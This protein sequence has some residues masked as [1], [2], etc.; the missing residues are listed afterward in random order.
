M[1]Q[2]PVAAQ[3]KF[4][5]AGMCMV[6]MA[7]GRRCWPMRQGVVLLRLRR[8]RAGHVGAEVERFDHVAGS[9]TWLLTEV[10]QASVAV[11]RALM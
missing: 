3:E 7:P 8:G 11:E 5:M 10:C 6:W 9:S 1:Y 2:D 4:A